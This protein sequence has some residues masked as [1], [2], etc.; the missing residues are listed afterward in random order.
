MSDIPTP[1]ELD[2]QDA[3]DEEAA[4][5]TNDVGAQEFY[6]DKFADDDPEASDG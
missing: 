3:D 4:I 5:V 6:D 2:E 1:A